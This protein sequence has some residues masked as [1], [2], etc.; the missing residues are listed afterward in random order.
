M[1]AFRLDKISNIRV[2][3]P[4]WFRKF[5]ACSLIVSRIACVFPVTARHELLVDT[6]PPSSLASP[7]A[8]SK[9]QLLPPPQLPLYGVAYG[10]IGVGA[11][12]ESRSTFR[13]LWSE[14]L[15][16]VRGEGRKF[17]MLAISGFVGVSNLRTGPTL[18]AT[19]DA[20]SVDGERLCI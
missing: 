10:P 4:I 8:P 3:N 7:P 14:L 6:L 19:G 15:R 20:V 18:F 5:H 9:A 2:K 13:L 17:G 11:R 1:M 16:V 12:L